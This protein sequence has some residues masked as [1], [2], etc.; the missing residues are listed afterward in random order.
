MDPSKSLDL[1]R[2]VHDNI[3]GPRAQSKNRANFHRTSR[4]LRLGLHLDENIQVAVGSGFTARMTTKED[5]PPGVKALNDGSRNVVQQRSVSHDPVAII[6]QIW[7]SWAR[8]AL[9]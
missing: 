8:A 9:F 6:P 5:N 2:R 7:V 1:F 4:H 3:H